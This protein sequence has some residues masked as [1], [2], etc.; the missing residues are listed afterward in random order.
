[1]A[2]IYQR[3]NLTILEPINYEKAVKL[4]EWRNAM[5]EEIYIIENNQTWV[6][7]D[8]PCNKNI[9]GVKWIFRTKLN[10]DGLINKHK[11]RLIAKGYSQQPRIDFYETFSLIA[12]L[13]TIMLLLAL[14][15]QKGWKIYQLDVKSVFLNGFLEEGIYVKQLEGFV[16]KGS[17]NKVYQIKKALY[18][19]K[20]APRARN[21][22]IDDHLLKSGFKKS[23]S[24]ATLYIKAIERNDVLTVI[25]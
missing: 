14:A 12:R 21:S 1:M 19:L 9:I 25:Y 17:E 7:V 20:Q 3:Y 24:E 5:Q 23:L 2:D 6:L 15:A 10:T 11:A 16:T 22:K 8:K 4:S 13:D 18:W